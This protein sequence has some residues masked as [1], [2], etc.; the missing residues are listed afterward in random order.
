MTED[1]KVTISLYNDYA[2]QCVIRSS[3]PGMLETTLDL[4]WKNSTNIKHRLM[5]NTCE[6]T[7]MHSVDKYCDNE[8]KLIIAGNTDGA[9][10]AQKR[11]FVDGF[12][13]RSSLARYI[14]V[15]L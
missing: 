14:E 10:K 5:H 2:Q 11:A 3:I 8:Y 4:L 6:L 15:R 12:R 13:S 9:K 7:K 1:A